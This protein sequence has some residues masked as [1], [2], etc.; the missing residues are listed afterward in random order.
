[1]TPTENKPRIRT[2]VEKHYRL[3]PQ[4]LMELNNA[5]SHY[6]SLYRFPVDNLHWKHETM[7]YRDDR[8]IILM[9]IE[10]FHFDNQSRCYHYFKETPDTI[11][12]GS[13]L[14]FDLPDG[15][16][17]VVYNDSN[18]CTSVSYGENEWLFIKGRIDDVFVPRP[19]L[20]PE[21]KEYMEQQG[22]LLSGGMT[23]EQEIEYERRQAESILDVYVAHDTYGNPLIV[24]RWFCDEL[25]EIFM[26]EYT[27]DVESNE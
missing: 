14:Y 19:E 16:T 13:K 12:E 9:S 11:E 5:S 24:E 27:Y 15:Q 10:E 20:T 1:M 23:D 25:E 22:Q 17:I 8:P 3:V 21:Q 2:K 18:A 6:T 26:Y 7:L 4:S